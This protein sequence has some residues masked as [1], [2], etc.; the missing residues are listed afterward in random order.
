[1][2]IATLLATVAALPAGRELAVLEADAKLDAAV[3]ACRTALALGRGV[4]FYEEAMLR[5]MRR[6]QE[7]AA[8]IDVEFPEGGRRCP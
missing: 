4:S 6:R 1:M 7:A 2:K 3:V 5:A 8:R